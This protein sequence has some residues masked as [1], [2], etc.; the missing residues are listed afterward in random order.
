M[1]G[2]EARRRSGAGLS[3][4]AA[5]VG[6]IEAVGVNGD[7]RGAPCHVETQSLGTQEKIPI[8]EAVAL[9]AFVESRELD[10]GILTDHEVLRCGRVCRPLECSDPCAACRDLVLVTV[11][12]VAAY[13]GDRPYGEVVARFHS[14]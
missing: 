5:H 1:S 4:L 12:E 14:L 3:H 10:E 11:P 9:I 8:F 7:C 6:E 2:C 13:A